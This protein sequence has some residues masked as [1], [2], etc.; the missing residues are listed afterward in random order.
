MWAQL[1]WRTE[2]MLKQCMGW[3]A[4]WMKWFGCY[5]CAKQQ[6]CFEYRK[7]KYHSAN[8]KE[9]MQSSISIKCVL[10]GQKIWTLL[11]HF[12]RIL[13]SDPAVNCLLHNPYNLNNNLNEDVF[14]RGYILRALDSGM[15]LRLLVCHPTSPL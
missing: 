8:N 9:G 6:D 12:F 13:C 3:S 1:S 4:F 10:C 5:L 15:F 7:K 14:Y 11:L 2:I